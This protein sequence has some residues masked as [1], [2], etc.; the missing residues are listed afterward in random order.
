MPVR[1]QLNT[2]AS[3]QL[4]INLQNEADAHAAVNDAL[5]SRSFNQ[6]KATRKAYS[7][8]QKLWRVSLTRAVEGCLLIF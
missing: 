1:D 7:V 5:V 8:G 2:Q 6:P 4:Q 3:T